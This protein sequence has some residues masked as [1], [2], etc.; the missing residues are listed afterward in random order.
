MLT[1]AGPGFQP[2]SDLKACAFYVS[3]SPKE[4]LEAV[5]LS[6][7]SAGMT[8]AHSWWARGPG[9]PARRPPC[10]IARPSQPCP[11]APRLSV[12]VLSRYCGQALL[13]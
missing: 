7:R 1:V 8:R 4:N 11:E 12:S 9:S 10:C 3:L 2:G 6:Q 13:S 5:F